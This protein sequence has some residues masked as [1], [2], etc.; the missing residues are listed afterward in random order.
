M[1]H[2][3]AGEEEECAALSGQPHCT[4]SPGRLGHGGVEAP[5]L[6][7]HLSQ[8]AGV[9][10]PVL[11]PHAGLACMYV[12]T[13]QQQSPLI[14]RVHPGPYTAIYGSCKAVV[15]T[16]IISSQPLGEMQLSQTAQPL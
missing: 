13:G 16:S 9:L 11:S 5:P 4:D 1:R 2:T 7:L 8:Q 14:P 3:G 15:V 10:T 12:P 6:L